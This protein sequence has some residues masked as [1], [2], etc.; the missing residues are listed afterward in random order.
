MR[1][2]IL[3]TAV[4]LFVFVHLVGAVSS[5]H[6]DQLTFP[7]L[8]LSFPQ[9]EDYQ[10]VNGMNVYF[11]TDEE[12]P[13]VDLTV[14]IRGGSI[15][16]PL[17]K[18]GLAQ[19]FSR[20]LETGGTKN[21]TPEQLE[22]ELDLMAAELTVSNS[23]YSYQVD[24]SIHQRDL[25]RAMEILADLLRRPRFDDDRVELARQQL[26]ASV[27]RRNDRPAG[28]AGRYL[29]Q[30][31][32]PGHPFGLEPV[33]ETVNNLSREDLHAVHERFFQPQHLW[34]GV[35]GA[36]TEEQ[37]S[38]LLSR[39]FAD[40]SRHA[41]VDQE[42]PPLPEPLDAATYVVDRKLSQTT[43]MMG[44]RGI[45]KDNPDLHAVRLANYILGGGGFNSR[46]MREIRSNR[47]L[48]YSI[49]SRFQPGRYLPELFTVAGE[50]R[51]D[52]AIEVMRLVRRLIDEMREVP[53]SSEEI[54]SAKRSLINSFIFA[55]ENT[56]AVVTQKMRL[57]F[58]SYPDDYLESYQER[59][60]AL[61]AADVQ[62]V[63]RFYLQPERLHVVLVGDS[64]ILLA[65][66][67][68]DDD[69]VVIE[70]D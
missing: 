47:G 2:L 18:I 55:F 69:I 11:K 16:D 53:V 27:H 61:T 13:L 67:D 63:A 15:H 62:R 17:E 59:I 40:W 21:Y 8:E 50:T 46:L 65:D 5:Q 58:Y 26:I 32:N 37:F 24:L 7:P 33:L 66:L 45:S 9:I 70:L 44:H 52:S 49:Y 4:I 54:E 64:D 12:L 41:E 56:H 51:N 25:T 36:V 38:A 29:A 39:H 35:S 48:A 20:S 14:M 43:L 68:D 34:W 28:I 22:Q 60:E 1:K 57:D 10:T 30:A 42:F 6:P 31:V 23:S 19:L 3:I